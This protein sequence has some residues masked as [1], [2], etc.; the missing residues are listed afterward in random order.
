MAITDTLFIIPNSSDNTKVA[1]FSTADIPTGVQ[2]TYILPSNGAVVAADTIVT[3]GA[4]QT[5]NNKTLNNATFSGTLSVE[6][7]QVNGTLHLVM[8]LQIVLQ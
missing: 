7:I 5:L 8:L 1:R 3:L 2:H 4:S 6:T